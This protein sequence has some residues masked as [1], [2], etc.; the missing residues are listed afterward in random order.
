MCDREP[1]TGQGL[2]LNVLNTIPAVH[3][4]LLPSR[5]GNTNMAHFKREKEGERVVFSL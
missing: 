4:G 3:E 2:S 5:K 1:K